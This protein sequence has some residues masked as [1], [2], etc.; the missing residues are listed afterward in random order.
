MHIFFCLLTKFKDTW[1]SFTMYIFHMPLNRMA[2]FMTKFICDIINMVCS[3]GV[4][5][6]P[7]GFKCFWFVLYVISHVS[8]HVSTYLSFLKH[9]SIMYIRKIQKIKIK[10]TKTQR[11]IAWLNCLWIVAHLQD[12]GTIPIIR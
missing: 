7:S 11:K 8:W 4:I 3:K 6:Y 2:N 9:D 1:F 12:D 5:R 10:T